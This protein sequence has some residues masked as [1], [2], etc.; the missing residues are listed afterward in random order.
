MRQEENLRRIVV[1]VDGSEP[2]KQALRWA[3]EQAALSGATVEAVGA[4]EYQPNYGWGTVAAIDAA[5][6]ADACERTVVDAVIDVGGEEPPVRI[7]S[8]IVRGHP[9]NELVQQAKGADLLVVGSR[10]HGGFVGALL[11]SV[12][13]HCVHHATCPVV[14]V[15]DQHSES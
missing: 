10:G 12:S 13:Q 2:S 5:E 8:Y 9:A 11:G 14:I 6:L 15:R 7:D 4:W 1:G 3:I